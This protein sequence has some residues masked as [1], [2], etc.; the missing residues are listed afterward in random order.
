MP[1]FE[2]SGVGFQVSAL[3]L[4]ADI[5]FDRKRNESPP[6]SFRRGLS[7]TPIREPESRQKKLDPGLRRGD[8]ERK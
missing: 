8:G 3:P 1:L 6:P 4:A 2:V 5:Q 7:R